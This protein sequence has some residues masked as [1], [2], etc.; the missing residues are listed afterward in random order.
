MPKALKGVMN[1]VAILKGEQDTPSMLNEFSYIIQP[2][3]VSI[4]LTISF[5]FFFSFL[6]PLYKN[7]FNNFP[8]RKVS[9]LDTYSKQ[10]FNHG[11][12]TRSKKYTCKDRSYIITPIKQTKKADSY[13]LAIN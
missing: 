7:A 6:P 5:F 10:T 12:P 11:G 2:I 3:R 13:I 8:L 4:H 9:T 1:R